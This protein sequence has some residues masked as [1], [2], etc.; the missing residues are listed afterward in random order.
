LTQR[1]IRSNAV[2][3][4]TFCSMSVAG[5]AQFIPLPLCA[6]S[7]WTVTGYFYNPNIHPFKEFRSTIDTLEDYAE[8]VSLE[9]ISD[10]NYGLTGFIQSVAFKEKTRCT[11]CYISRLEETVKTASARGFDSFSTT[12]LYSRYQN[13]QLLKEICSKL[14]EQYRVAFVYR[15]FR[16]GW[17]LGVDKSI[18][19]EMY[20][21][22]YC[23]CIY[24]EQE[25]YDKSL[26][27]K[28][29]QDSG[30]KK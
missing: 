8:G 18:E 25:R 3:N 23:G 14:A 30:S 19:M 26:R 7:R 24:S 21:Q 29:K 4:E 16:Q 17:Q 6:I 22:P 9:L 28:K 11:I 2:T 27:K 1:I 15:D 5:H 10:D 20:R 13:H 12:L